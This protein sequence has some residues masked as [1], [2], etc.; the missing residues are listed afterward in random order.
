MAEK[1]PK[2][3]KQIQDYEASGGFEDLILEGELVEKNGKNYLWD[4]KDAGAKPFFGAKK[5]GSDE[6]FCCAYAKD[7][8]VAKINAGDKTFTSKECLAL[9]DA[10]FNWM[11]SKKNN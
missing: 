3:T 5:S 11:K 6:S 4:V 7:V 1:C 9:A 10:F 2:L 8:W